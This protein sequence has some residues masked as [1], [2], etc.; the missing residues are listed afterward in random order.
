MPLGAP[1]SPYE[2]NWK[3]KAIQPK[4]CWKDPFPATLKRETERETTATAVAPRDRLAPGVSGKLRNR[5]R[6]PHAWCSPAHP[7]PRHV[8]RLPNHEGPASRWRPSHRPEESPVGLECAHA[9]PPAKTH[10]SPTA[11]AEMPRSPPTRG[12]TGCP[13]PKAVD[14]YLSQ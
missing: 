4:N 3:A 10:Q 2:P 5:H 9:P 14:V 11:T 1:R 12:A 13:H 7:G 8:T 6:S